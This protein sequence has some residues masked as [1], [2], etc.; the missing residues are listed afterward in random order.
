MRIEFTIK[1]GE[2]CLD[3]LNKA[4]DN[5][6]EYFGFLTLIFASL[7]IFTQVVLRFAFNYSLYWSEEMARYL[8][9]WFIFIGSSIAVREKA[10]ATVDVLFVYLPAFHK[11][12]L[13]I[14][15]SVIAIIFCV[16]ITVSGFQTIKNVVEFSNITPALEI[17]M[18][19][20]YLAIPFGSS[21]MLYRFIQ[22]LLDDV[23]QLRLGTENIQN[24]EGN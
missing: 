24:E 15:A 19:I 3:K 6:E 21:L 7:L 20:P 9:I 16:L 22:I 14:V 13:S 10:H 5:L 2:Y 17:P 18:Y 12:L 8:I 23:K 11:K 4:L 1:R